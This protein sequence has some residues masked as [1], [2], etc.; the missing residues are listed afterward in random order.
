MIIQLTHMHNAHCNAHYSE[1]SS[2]PKGSKWT[3][4]E[5]TE[6]GAA[7]SREGKRSKVKTSYTCCL[8]SSAPK[9]KLDFA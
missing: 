3:E 1:I 8:L 7:V 4:T 5:N 2:V 9:I 6:A